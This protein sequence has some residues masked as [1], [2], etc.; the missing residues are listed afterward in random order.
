MADLR[1]CSI[2]ACDNP[3]RTR[4]WCAIHYNRWRKTGDVQPHK[5]IKKNSPLADVC[6]VD[7]CSNPPRAKNLCIYHYTRERRH[8]DPTSGPSR[9]ST[10]EIERFFNEVVLPY[11]GDECLTWPFTRLRDGRGQYRKRLAHRVVCEIVNGPPPTPL[12]QAAHN[13]GNGHLGCVTKRHLQWKTPA[14][15]AADK[16][17]HGTIPRGER[18]ASSKLTREDVLAIRRMRSD[19]RMKLKEIAAN[20]GIDQSTAS[21]ICSRKRWAWLD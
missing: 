9:R 6:L 17:R 16:V 13:C 2:E 8:G 18:Q 20:F 10:L 14:E 12:H 21:A 1:I 5:P 19:G 3:S 7:G 11:D 15:N 4:G